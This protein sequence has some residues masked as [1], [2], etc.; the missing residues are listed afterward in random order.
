MTTGDCGLI[1]D[2]QPAHTIH[3]HSSTKRAQPR[4]TQYTHTQALKD[5]SRAF[6][7]GFGASAGADVSAGLA[8]ADVSAGLEGYRLVQADTH[9]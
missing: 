6:L 2:W 9:S 8:G 1:S 4:F 7:V 3:S 5:L